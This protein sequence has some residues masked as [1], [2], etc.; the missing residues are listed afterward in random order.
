MATVVQIVTMGARARRKAKQR[1]RQRRQY[2]REREARVAALRVGMGEQRRAA[3][4]RKKV[5]E[6]HEGARQ[7]LTA[8]VVKRQVR[9]DRNLV[10]VD[11][12]PLLPAAALDGDGIHPRDDAAARDLALNLN[13]VLGFSRRHPGEARFL[14]SAAR[15][16]D[17]VTTCERVA[18]GPARQRWAVS[19]LRG[20]RDRAD[21]AVGG[22]T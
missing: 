9:G 12:P 14:A 15:V 17:D 13:A 10:V 1:Q 5:S 6:R 19:T 2:K 11:G 7:Q 8:E 20:L 22:C 21:T 16:F 3:D 4:L 18:D